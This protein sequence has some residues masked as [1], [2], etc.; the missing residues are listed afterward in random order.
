MNKLYLQWNDLGINVYLI[1]AK[2]IKIK[3]ELCTW[4]NN[5][6]LKL[7]ECFDYNKFYVCLTKII[8]LDHSI[9]DDELIKKPLFEITVL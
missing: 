3:D 2:T 7:N 4:F 9:T 6:Y 8:N 5:N 1:D